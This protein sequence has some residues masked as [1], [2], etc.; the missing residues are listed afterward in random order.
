MNFEEF[1]YHWQDLAGALTGAFAGAVIP[2]ILYISAK[3]FEKRKIRK[4]NLQKLE[5]LMVIN[6]NA[7]IEVKKELSSHECNWKC[8]IYLNAFSY[9]FIAR[10]LIK[11]C[12]S[13]INKFR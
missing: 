2:I 10:V 4:E 6:I 3:R 7:T 1:L 5:K 11:C 8:A 9:F 13:F 12:I